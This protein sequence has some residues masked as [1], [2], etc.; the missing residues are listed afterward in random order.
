MTV[1]TGIWV[2]QILANPSKTL[3]KYAHVATEDL[4]FGE[5]LE[6]WNSVTGKKAAIV[7]CSVEDFE[8]VWGIAGTE[9]AQQLKYGETVEDWDAGA[10]G[11][12]VSM[13]ELGITEDI[14]FKKSLES[15][16]HLLT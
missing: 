10:E 14:G 7:E 5:M 15:L 9:I 4:T 2:R 12:V 3:G 1:S 11:G 13:K 8:H 16:K 6:I